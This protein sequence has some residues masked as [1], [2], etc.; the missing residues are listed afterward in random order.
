MHAKRLATFSD[1][2]AVRIETLVEI[3]ETRSVFDSYVE[4]RFARSFGAAGTRWRLRRKPEPFLVGR[5][6]MIPDFSFEKNSMK[7]YL[8]VVGFWTEEYLAKKVQKLKEAHASN[9]IVAVDKTLGCSRFKGLRMEVIFYEGCSSEAYHRLL[10]SDG[11]GRG[12]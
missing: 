1:S 4:E 9:M 2:T 11:G 6:V 8:E 3:Q 10:E 5:H 12:R 7:A